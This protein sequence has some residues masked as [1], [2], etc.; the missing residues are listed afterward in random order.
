MIKEMLAKGFDQSE[1][2]DYLKKSDEIFLNQLLKGKKSKSRT[3]INRGLKTFMLLMSLGLLVAIFY[4]YATV[5]LIGLFI[6]WSLIKY[7]SYRK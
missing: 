4:G 6:F 5:G 3:T 2:E 1:I 7:G